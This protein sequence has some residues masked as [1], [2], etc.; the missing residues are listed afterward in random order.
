MIFS[1]PNFMHYKGKSLKMDHTFALLQDCK[2]MFW[3]LFFSKP[4]TLR[5][6][7]KSPWKI[8][9][10]LRWIFQPAIGQFPTDFPPHLVL[11][12]FYSNETHL[13]R[14]IRS[15]LGMSIDMSISH[16]GGISGCTYPSSHNH[17]SRKWDVSN[18]S[19]L[20]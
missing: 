7:N 8:P 9:I 19:F 3:F 11:R 20:R 4:I 12:Y 5:Y 17:G 1:N 13:G 15:L 14:F 2:R 6:T 10:F 16:Q 18:I